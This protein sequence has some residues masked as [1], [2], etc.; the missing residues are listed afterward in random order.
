MKTRS[1]STHQVEK[2]MKI[3]YDNCTNSNS[4][5]FTGKALASFC[6][7]SK[8]LQAIQILEATNEIRC[9]YVDGSNIPLI[10]WLEDNGIL[11]FF[12]KDE[13]RKAAIKGFILGCVTGIFSS[14]VLPLFLTW[15]TNMLHL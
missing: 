8:N 14:V 11:H 13:K 2:T 10:I 15:L 7:D 3:I 4:G 12:N 1:I 6:S 5:A 9:S